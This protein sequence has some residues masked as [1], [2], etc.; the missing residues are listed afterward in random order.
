MGSVLI[1]KIS[2]VLL[3]PI[4]SRIKAV[5]W[6]HHDSVLSSPALFSLAQR[7]LL[8]GGGKGSGWR[9]WAQLG[10]VVGHEEDCDWSR[11]GTEGS[12]CSPY[13]NGSLN[14]AGGGQAS[15]DGVRTCPI[16]SGTYNPAIW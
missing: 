12:W 8:D 10:F 1:Q 7:L 4:A 11:A 3:V 9:L 13:I 16:Q 14:P 6:A 5:R 15:L 2:S